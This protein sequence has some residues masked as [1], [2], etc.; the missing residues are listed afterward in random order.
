M[1]RLQT[2][3]VTKSQLPA[4][5][6]VPRSQFGI[7]WRSSLG[8]PEYGASLSTRFFRC[9]SIADVMSD[10]GRFISRCF[11][12]RIFRI[13]RDTMLR[14]FALAVLLSALVFGQTHTPAARLEQLD[15]KS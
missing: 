4:L 13:R 5:R 7:S 9:Q 3:T 1:G 12:L 11:R 15:R 14:Q 8:K 2:Q 10:T 6:R